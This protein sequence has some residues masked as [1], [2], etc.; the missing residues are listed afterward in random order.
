MEK[1]TSLE[2]CAGAG[3][4]TLGMDVAADMLAVMVDGK[5]LKDI[6]A[7]PLNLAA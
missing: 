2:L 3:G 6:S 5:Q 7:L 4:Q 1:F